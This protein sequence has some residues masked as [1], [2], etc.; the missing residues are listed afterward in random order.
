MLKTRVLTV[1]VLLPLLLAA[2]AYMPPAAGWWLVALLAGLGAREWCRLAGVESA[3]VGWTAGLSMLLL[4]GLVIS[5]V[6]QD[7]LALV[8]LAAA[9]LWSINGLWLAR[10]HALA[11]HSWR[12]VALKGAVG[13]GVLVLG[14]AALG[15]LFAAPD[16]R[17]RL[18]LFLLVIWAADIG[19][20]AAGRVLGRHKLAPTIS[21]GKTWEGVFGGQLMV[22]LVVSALAAFDYPLAR[23]LA[24][25]LGWAALSAA[26]SVVGD[27]FVSLLKRQRGLKD[28]GTI[29]PGHGGVLD[30]F[31]SVLA[32]APVFAWGLTLIR[33]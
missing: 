21:P 14:G 28:T 17:F 6:S 7:Q 11:A 29:F 31:D 9:V 16:G 12:A 13:L 25:L 26:V 24:P 20:Y 18:L 33:T 2:I 15:A 1:I 30:R 22:A 19:A 27:L 23:P 32:A 8:G 10:R 3:L 4:V 5:R